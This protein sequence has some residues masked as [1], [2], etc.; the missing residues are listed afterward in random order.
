MIARKN[1]TKEEARNYEKKRFTR[2][3]EMKRLNNFEKAFAQ[4][5]FSM[6]GSYS[7][8]VDIPCGNGRF[9]N[10]F[11]DARELTM[12]DRSANMLEA[13]KEKFGNSENVRFLQADIL[14]IPLPDSSADLCFSM[15]LFHHMQNDQDRLKALEELARISRKYV[16]ISFYNKN[17]LRFYWR[18]VLSKKIRGYYV[19]FDHIANLAKYTGLDPVE[20]FPKLNLIEQQCLVILKKT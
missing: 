5:L 4:R 16:A 6:T 1:I 9:F 18:K 3:Y 2:R 17:C 19:T 10:I 14:S 15:R 20:R 8:I 11:S 12:I 7:R 13:C